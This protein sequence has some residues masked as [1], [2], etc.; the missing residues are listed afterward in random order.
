MKIKPL[1]N[2]LK[3]FIIAELSGNHNHSY[4]LAV[5]TIKAMKESGADA[6]KLQTYTP[7]TITLNSDKKYFRITQGTIWDGLTLYNL[8]KQAY[9]PWDWFPKLQKLAE[10]IGLIFFSTPFDNSAVDFLENL[11]VPCYKIASYEINDIPL[12]RY[13]ASKKKPMMIS[14][15]LAEERDI[16]EAISACHKEGNNNITLLKCTSEYP[17][18][19]SEVNLLTIPDMIRRFNVNVGISDHTVGISVPIGA[20]SLGARVVEKHFILDRSLGG[21]DATFSLEPSEFSQMVRGIRQI[22]D[23]LGKVTY[24]LS[25]K[26]KIASQLGRSLFVSKDIKKGELFTLDNIRSVRPAFGL[27]PIN[28]FKII[29]KRASVNIKYGEPLRWT[30][31]EK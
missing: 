7:D 26:A 3:V 19:F 13:V 27:K 2:P 1:Y 14:T 5:K 16:K 4:E 31:V 11:N 15:G 17:A 29:G 23:A 21:P 30:M 24:K 8:Y 20:V 10:K 12:I 9:T 25:P 18:S 28:I 22:E 6:V